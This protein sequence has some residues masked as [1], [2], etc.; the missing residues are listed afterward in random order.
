MEKG[1]NRNKPRGTN[2]S[3]LSTWGSDYEVTYKIIFLTHDLLLYFKYHLSQDSE[4]EYKAYEW[5][6][7]FH[8][9]CT[10]GEFWRKWSW[11]RDK[12]YLMSRRNI[13][14]I[15][16]NPTSCWGREVNKSEVKSQLVK[17]ERWLFLGGGV[18]PK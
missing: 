15:C 1:W 6:L 11:F 8:L 3:G 13:S 4:K 12:E 2:A 17:D 9:P 18:I 5:L 7:N 14:S 10:L 16:V